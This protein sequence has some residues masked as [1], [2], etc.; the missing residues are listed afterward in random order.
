[1]VAVGATVGIAV[2]HLGGCSD[3]KPVSTFNDTPTDGG[4]GS[5]GGPSFDPD[6]GLTDAFANTLCTP[7][8]PATFAPTWSPPTKA[9]KCTTDE[10]G[11]YFDACST[12]LNAQAC[13]DWLSG[14]ADCGGCVQKTDNTGPIQTFRDGLYLLLNTAGCISLTIQA[15]GGTDACAKAFDSAAQCRR[16]SCDQCFAPNLP[17]SQVAFQNFNSCE[18]GASCD[19]WNSDENT[20]CAPGASKLAAQCFPTSTEGA[21]LNGADTTARTAAQRSFYVRVMGVTCGS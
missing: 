19:K 15:D 21:A 8:L 6:S 5:E 1:L 14:H 11:G 9:A 18:Q 16:Q 10:L 3:D 20:A 4:L 17:S 12:S 13:K 2:L 7:Q